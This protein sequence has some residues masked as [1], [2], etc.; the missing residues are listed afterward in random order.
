MKPRFLLLLAAVACAP[1]SSTGGGASPT[2]AA[3]GAGSGA[4]APAAPERPAAAREHGKAVALAPAS[5]VR[6]LLVRYDTVTVQLPN[7]STSMQAYE[8]DAWLDTRVSPETDGFHVVITLDSLA[9]AGQFV[10]PQEMLDSARGTRWT[11][12]LGRNGRLSSLEADRHT[13]MGEQFEPMLQYLYPVLP[14]STV[15][16][17]ATWT[18]STVTPIT[19]ENFQGEEQVT[20]QYAATGPAVHGSHTVL[21]VQGRGTFARTGTATQAGQE[22]HLT[23]T[24]QRVLTHFLV[25]DGTVDGMEGS[26]TSDL[27]YT[28]PSQGQTLSASQSGS[29]RVTIVPT[30]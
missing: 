22:M 24:G 21:T 18:D 9:V 10:P 28:I 3:A 12:H 1:S 27:S 30:P 19:A 8:R 29:F 5:F 6:Y 26:E 25:T 17:G 11:A 23:S 7:G 15:R 4:A 13:S 20:L 14:D 2:P 16:P